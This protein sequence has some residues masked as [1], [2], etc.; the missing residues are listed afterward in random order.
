MARRQRMK[1]NKLLLALFV[2]SLVFIVVPARVF[3]EDNN[4]E[5]TNTT[6]NETVELNVTTN[7]TANTTVNATDN[8]N[9]HENDDVAL[10]VSDDVD[11]ED[12]ILGN[13]IHGM[14]VRLLQLHKSLTKNTEHGTLILNAINKQNF[15]VDTDNLENILDDANNLNDRISDLLNE[16]PVNVSTE[17]FVALKS[18]AINLTF[19]FRKELY[20]ILT[21]QQLNTIRSDLRGDFDKNSKRIND[22]DSR[23]RNKSKE[24]NIEQA[25]KIY[26]RFDLNDSNLRA[27]IES[28]N[29]TSKEL[30]DALKNDFKNLKKEMKQKAEAKI[31][32]EKSKYQEAK[33]KISGKHIG[34][35]RTEV[36][37][38]INDGSLT[39]NEKDAKV[40]ILAKDKRQMNQTNRM[41]DSNWQGMNTNRTDSDNF[42]IDRR[43]MGQRNAP[44]NMPPG[45]NKGR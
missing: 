43:G 18:E 8:E 31:K 33:I 16:T 15:S 17:E 5:T 10:N 28:G 13:S 42:T 9:E 22:I 45:K 19:Q 34:L 2:V 39:W 11:L 7:T 23:I 36:E 32:E 3:A 38:I 24:Y 40:R 4:N 1:L 30:R 26:D 44:G 12:V 35:N 41:N 6:I 37:N 29:F 20:N 14:E 27:R 21:P 25:L